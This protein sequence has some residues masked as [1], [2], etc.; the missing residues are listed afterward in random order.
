MACPN[1][2]F[3]RSTPKWGSKRA[4]KPSRQPKGSVPSLG[5]PVLDVSVG[6]ILPGNVL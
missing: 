5:A 6:A 2:V 3:R 1:P 4:G